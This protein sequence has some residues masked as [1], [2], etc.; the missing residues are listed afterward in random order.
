MA[1]SLSYQNW[2]GWLTIITTLAPSLEPA[3][4]IRTTNPLHMARNPIPASH[5]MA[6][7]SS[8]KFHE[9]ATRPA[10]TKGTN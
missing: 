9:G 4:S 3:K 6:E 5:F 2:N 1:V 7:F 8:L 10:S